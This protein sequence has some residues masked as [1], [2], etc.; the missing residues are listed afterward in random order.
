MKEARDT[1]A[2]ALD[3]TARGLIPSTVT[4]VFTCSYTS[5]VNKH[6]TP[7]MYLVGTVGREILDGDYGAVPF[8]HFLTWG[9]VCFFAVAT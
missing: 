5:I 6:Y 4:L 2:P 3:D 9:G 1:G 8:A 7:V